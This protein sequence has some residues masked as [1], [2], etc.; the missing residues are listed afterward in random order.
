MPKKQAGSFGINVAV[1]KLV[2]GGGEFTDWETSNKIVSPPQFGCAL[3]TETRE[4]GIIIEGLD[5]MTSG[6]AFLQSAWDGDI[7]K[8]GLDVMSP[9]VLDLLSANKSGC[10][11]CRCM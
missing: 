6:Q 7:E 11:P 5:P 9:I 4:F 8:E 10:E 2:R 3:A 1:E